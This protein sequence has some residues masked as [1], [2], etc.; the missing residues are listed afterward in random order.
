M[1]AAFACGIIVDEIQTDDGRYVIDGGLVLQNGFRLLYGIGGPHHRCAPRKLGD[2]KKRALIVF[3]Q[4]A[5]R[6]DF[7]Q[8]DDAEGGDAYED[9]PDDRNAHEAGD[10]GAIGV[11]DANRWSA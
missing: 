8:G 7:R 6:R 10:D 11:A 3:R 9:K 5:G 1:K 2:D 4:K